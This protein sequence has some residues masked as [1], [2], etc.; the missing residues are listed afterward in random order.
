MK[1]NVRKNKLMLFNRAKRVDILPEV[2]YNESTLIELVEEM[3]LLG[4]IIS[5]NLSW[6]SNTNALVAKGIKDFGC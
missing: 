5:S 3:K 1:F 6:K 2:H 4:I